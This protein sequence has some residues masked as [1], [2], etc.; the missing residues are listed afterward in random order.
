MAPFV[1]EGRKIV[2]YVGGFILPDGTASAQRCLGVATLMR[3][4]GFEVVML[5]KLS[6][7][8]PSKGGTCQTVIQAFQCYDIRQPFWGKSYGSYVHSSHSLE[9]VL[10]HIGAHRVHS[11]IAYNYPARA[12]AKLL[13]ICR[14]HDIAPVAECT[15]WYGWEGL[16][17]I[18]NL[19]RMTAAYWRA[20]VLAPKA[21][22]I[23]LTSRYLVKAYP[24]ANVLVLP[25]VVNGSD[26]KWLTP[27]RALGRT[28][29]RFVYAGSP[30]AGLSKDKINYA[31]QA[32]ACHK[33]EGYDF[34]L[35][36]V[37]ITEQQYLSARPQDR[38]LLR[39][40]ASVITF[41]GRV[42]HTDALALL[43]S[44]DFSVFFRDPNRVASVGFPTKYAE[45]VSC[46]V[47]T[48]T[49]P[50]SD[51]PIFIQDGRNGLLARGHDEADIIHVLERALR[52]SPQDL[53]NMKS[54]VAADNPFHY[55]RWQVQA[56]RFMEACE[57]S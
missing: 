36:I 2:L 4:L 18:R 26:P 19:Q 46:G 22:N 1:R 7:Q 54:A 37:G 3:S 42:S 16:N 41:H 27:A 17:P 35:E 9:D 44:A 15:E 38:S 10:E 5:G 8:P 53:Q 21:G 31:V 6:P 50:T 56:A 57:A 30:G 14:R 40:L 34:A 47:P 51:L 29:V 12:L 25:F 11:I 20:M 32:F 49:N 23:I 13:R 33:R 55:E 43:R 24:A 48:I 28:R 45:A 52:M 39:E